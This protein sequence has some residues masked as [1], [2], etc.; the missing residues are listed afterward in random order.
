MDN[1][2]VSFLVASH[3]KGSFI[4]ECLWSIYCQTYSPIEIIVIENGST[5]QTEHVL[6]A[7]ENAPNLK[8]I[9]SSEPMKLS[10]ALNI[11]LKYAT[12]EWICKLDA[13]DLVD[14]DHV[15]VMMGEVDRHPDA[16]M[17][18]GD[19]LT[20]KPTGEKPVWHTDINEILN[21]CSV[22]QSST[23]IKKSVYDAL[24]GMDENLSFS[25]DWDFLIR[26]FKAGYKIYSCG[27]TGYVYRQLDVNADTQGRFSRFSAGRKENHEYLIKKH[28]L[29]IPCSCG[30]GAGASDDEPKISVCMI[31]KN[32]EQV[33]EACLDTV[34][35]FDEIVILDTGST[36]NTA[37]IARRYTDKYI[38][39]VY[40]WNDN[41]AEARNFAQKY[42]TGNWIFVI[43]ADERLEREGYYKC[44]RAVRAS[45]PEVDT[46]GVRTIAIGSNIEHESIRLYRNKPE[47]Y[48]CA[49]IHNYLNVLVQAHTDICVYYG[50]SP[51]HQIDPDRA[52]RILEKTN[53]T[54]PNAIREKFYLAREYLYREDW[55]T[56]LKWY[57]AYLKV[58]YWD[59]EKAEAWL[60]ISRCLQMLGNKV[61]AR[62]AA[63][64]SLDINPDFKHA[65][66]QL[67]DLT[68]GRIK[69]K[70]KQYASMATDQ[71]VLFKTI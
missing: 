48:W 20:V 70:W 18:Y 63:L 13:D 16:D 50:Y 51:A 33:L 58:A 43:D 2:K 12:G 60:H 71:G 59:P 66:E 7:F 32:E 24:G 52:L 55:K 21:G 62:I 67:A 54:T 5:D 6:V 29:V 10:Q 56:A 15:L 27:T 69:E 23:M 64:A 39:G 19:F 14:A 37:T 46:I 53:E 34:G 68:E 40:Q 3:N 9:R 57:E 30:C 61:G 38:S 17:I 8:I 44:K 35:L 65:L 22:S 25:D 47:V 31:V 49:P 28:N 4:A 26:V 1:P 42:C 41:F 45:P 11:G 36:D